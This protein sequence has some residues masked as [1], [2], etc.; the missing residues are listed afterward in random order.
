MYI[1]IWIVYNKIE[2]NKGVIRL[3]IK[4]VNQ[5]IVK[6]QLKIIDCCE[7]ELNY[8]N[9]HESYLSNVSVKYI[10]YTNVLN[11]TYDKFF[12]KN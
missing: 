7:N 9:D 1:Y 6:N 12:S 2:L 3:S 5:V 10:Y 4:E 11:D 8:Q